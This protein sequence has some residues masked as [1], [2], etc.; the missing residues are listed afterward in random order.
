MPDPITILTAIGI[1]MAAS[2]FAV[3]VAG[4]RGRKAGTAAID[5]G[6]VIGSGAGFLLGCC[7]GQDPALASGRRPRPP[8]LPG[9]SGCFPGRAA[10]RIS[11]CQDG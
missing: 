4:W 6:W 10:C 1:A 8:A 2:A 5:F 9:G 7:A 11:A 3:F